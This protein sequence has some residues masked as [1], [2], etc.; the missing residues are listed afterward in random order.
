MLFD[1]LIL[2]DDEDGGERRQQRGQRE[3]ERGG[4]YVVPVDGG[5]AGPHGVGLDVYHVVLL[6]VIGRRGVH[7]AAGRQVDGVGP[8]GVAFLAEHEDLGAVAVDGQVAGHAQHVKDGGLVAVEQVA[9]R[10]FH[11]AQH[12]HAEVGELYRDD[13]VLDEVPR[14]ELLLY[15]CGDLL[16]RHA[17]HKQA[18][19][20][21]E[22]DVAVGSHGVAQHALA[23]VERGAVPRH[24]DLLPHFRKVEQGS[25]LRVTAV[26]DD[27]ELV[28][29]TDCD[30]LRLFETVHV[31]RAQV[32]EVEHVLGRRAGTQQSKACEQQGVE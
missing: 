24:A 10:R 4:A 1:V 9:S 21:G 19:E 2:L 15:V 7:L 25:E 5:L 17:R 14:D 28:H 8:A 22:V 3:P 11:L 6:Q 26:D 12:G 23:V 30:V 20:Y 13:G 27:G 31:A 29:G 18:A 32:L 16:T